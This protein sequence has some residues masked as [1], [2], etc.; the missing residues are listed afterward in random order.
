VRRLNLHRLA[1]KHELPMVFVSLPGLEVN[2]VA[3]TYRTIS[4][5]DPAVISLSSDSYETELTVDADG[6]VL[7]YPGLARRS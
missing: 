3:Q 1:T 2:R 7:E 5:G 6:L 4:L